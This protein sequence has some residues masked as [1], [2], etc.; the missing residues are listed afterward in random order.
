MN[1]IAGDRVPRYDP[2]D[3]NL[4]PES[5]VNALGHAQFVNK[6]MRQE[7]EDAGKKAT[8][9]VLEA[10]ESGE[11]ESGMEADSSS[12]PSSGIPKIAVEKT[13]T[14]VGT[15][16]L[17]AAS[18][19]TFR[20]RISPIPRA[21][22]HT[23]LSSLAVP[24]HR[25]SA[26]L[27][28]AIN[29]LHSAHNKASTVS[30][31]PDTIQLFSPHEHARFPAFSAPGSRFVSVSNTPEHSRPPSRP[32]S[33]LLHATSLRPVASISRLPGLLMSKGTTSTI[34]EETAE[35][36]D[37][38]RGDNEHEHEEDEDNDGDGDGEGGVYLVL[39]TKRPTNCPPASVEDL[40]ALAQAYTQAHSTLSRSFSHA[41][42][43]ATIHANAN[44]HAQPYSQPTSRP[45]SRHSSRSSITEHLYLPGLGHPDVL[46]ASSQPATPTSS[47]F[48]E[49]PQAFSGIGGASTAAVAVDEQAGVARKEQAADEK[50]EGEEEKP[51]QQRCAIHDSEECDGETVTEVHPTERARRGVGFANAYPMIAGVDG[52]IMIDWVKICER[53]SGEME[54]E[55]ERRG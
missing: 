16:H 49:I 30:F 54:K 37:G 36:N 34:P 10:E 38:D 14:A 22:S 27:S 31:A 45:L 44:T 6:Q 7:R 52:R 46:R 19:T 3:P 42:I 25:S 17:R 8:A 55:S 32:T 13:A 41:N 15:V 35:D 1:G 48:T 24:A 51:R 26:S 20:R 2:N 4:R 53:V 39:R 23:S 47:K 9:K 33:P 50:A 11:K 5:S 29:T 43:Q 18:L 12:P 21:T 28:S 40:A